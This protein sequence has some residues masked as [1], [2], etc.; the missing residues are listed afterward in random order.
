MLLLSILVSGLTLQ[1]SIRTKV[2]SYAG[3][4][5]ANLADSVVFVSEMNTT[6]PRIS[7][8]S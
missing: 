5:L 1:S 6:T 2:A 3:N 8:P 7:T 4:E